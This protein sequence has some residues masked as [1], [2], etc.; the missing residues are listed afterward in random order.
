MRRAASTV[1]W[2]IGKFDQ[3]SSEFYPGIARPLAPG[4][5]QAQGKLVY[6]VGK[7]KPETDWPPFQ[8]GSANGAKTS[9]LILI[10]SSSIC[11]RIRA[12]FIP[13]R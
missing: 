7:S 13:S 11:L 1:V 8:P 12:A 4:A 9:G 6:V 10:P 3:S 2:Q 5:G